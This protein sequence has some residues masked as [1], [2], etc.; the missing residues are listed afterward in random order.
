[1]NLLTY[2]DF[3]EHDD[4]EFI[5]FWTSL[6]REYIEDNIET[7]SFDMEE[8]R[9]RTGERYSVPDEADYET[10]QYARYVDCTVN[11]GFFRQDDGFKQSAVKDY[12]SAI[13]DEY[14]ESSACPIE[15][16]RV[17][18]KPEERYRQ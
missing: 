15:Y 11:D 13:A 1:M 16:Q 5:E 3:D 12:E 14:D 7:L 17:D 4:D 10:Y 6:E 8:Q 2:A 9:F 18:T